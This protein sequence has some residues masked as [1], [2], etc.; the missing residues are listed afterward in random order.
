MKIITNERLNE[1]LREEEE[2]GREFIEWVEH[3]E[4]DGLLYTHWLD[5]RFGIHYLTRKARTVHM[6][7]NDSPNEKI[8]EVRRIVEA[9]G[10]CEASWG[11]TGRTMHSILAH[12]LSEKLPEYQFDIGYNYECK[13]SKRA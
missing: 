11:V 8:E 10:M 13:I 12:Q 4:Q 2:S 7:F 6:G 9:E 5:K 3:M 1:L